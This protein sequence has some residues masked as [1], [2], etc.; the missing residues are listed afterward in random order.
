[1]LPIE[2]Q[3]TVIGTVEEK[4]CP[5]IP[6]LRQQRICLLGGRFDHTV[7]KIALE[8]LGF[9]PGLGSPGGDLG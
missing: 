3:T 6:G 9:D 4:F 8:D 7:G 1:M 5:S 2:E